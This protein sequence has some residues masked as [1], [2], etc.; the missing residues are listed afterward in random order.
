MRNT[1]EG[2]D[3]LVMSLK[4]EVGAI[5]GSAVLI[6]FEICV[7]EALTNIV[8]H[9]K[10]VMTHAV[11][12]VAL[13]ETADAILVEIFDPLGATPFDLRDLAPDL[14]A[15]DLLAESGRGLGLIMQCADAVDYHRSEDRNCLKLEF[16]KARE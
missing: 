6:R 14:D 2:V 4:A 3:T 8:K 15:V 16:G 5:L 11:I 7:A 1:L 9:A 13:S 12:E 10:P